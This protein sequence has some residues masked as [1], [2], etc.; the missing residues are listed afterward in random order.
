MISLEGQQQFY[1]ER[2]AG[3]TFPG[4]LELER[5]SKIIE[6]MQH[7]GRYDDICD[8]GCGAGWISGVLGHFGRTTGIDLS[9]VTR[10]K[11]RFANCEF[12]SANILEWKHPIE[13]FDLVVSAEVIEHIPYGRQRDYI[14]V[15]HDLLRAGGSLI[16][17][18]PNKSTMNSIPSG[19]R[20]WSNQ[21]IEDWLD[22]AELLRL[23]E[24]N[25]FRVCRADTVTLGIGNLG[26]HRIVNSPK[27]NRWTDL[28]G[29]QP[30]WR[31]AA[32]RLGF[33]LHLAML[34]KKVA[35]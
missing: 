11:Q 18:T 17:T 3:F 24:D 5:I 21:P 1:D 7:A 9:D 32:L 26:L 31:A 33:G 6:L 29:L 8:L 34:A 14:Q 12:I 16:V 22:R 19:G 20:S 30:T 10:A 35:R 25:G 13:A 23:L 28:I 15:C 27:L 2:W 4:H